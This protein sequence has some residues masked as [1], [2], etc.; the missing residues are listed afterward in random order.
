M[1]ADRQLSEYSVSIENKDDEGDV[2]AT[3]H[4]GD[5]SFPIRGKK[6]AV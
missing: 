4:V 2:I 6:A 1:G 3:L 5:Q